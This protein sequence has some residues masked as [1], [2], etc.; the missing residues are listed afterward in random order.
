MKKTTIDFTNDKINILGQGIDIGFKTSGLYSILISKCYE[1]LNKFSNENYDSILL[2]IEKIAL[3]LSNEKR[4]IVEKL[5]KR[6][7]NSSTSNILKL[8]KTSEL[9]TM[10]F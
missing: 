1:T 5:H 4:K 9:G 3:K 2:P 6:F 10:N 8:V 7:R